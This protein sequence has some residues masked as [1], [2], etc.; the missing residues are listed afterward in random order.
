IHTFM[1]QVD[2]SYN[3]ILPPLSILNDNDRKK[4]FEKLKKINFNISNSLAA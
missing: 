4:L 2:N 3:N 1:A